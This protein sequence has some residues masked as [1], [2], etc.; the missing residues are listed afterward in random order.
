MKNEMGSKVLACWLEGLYLMG[1]MT[2]D[3]LESHDLLSINKQVVRVSE[4]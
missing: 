4:L 2:T 3:N 1:H